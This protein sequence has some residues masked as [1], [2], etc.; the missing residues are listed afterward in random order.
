M[1]FQFFDASRMAR[2]KAFNADGGAFDVHRAF[3]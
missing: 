1:L 3:A 2:N